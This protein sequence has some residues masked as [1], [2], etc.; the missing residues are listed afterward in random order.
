MCVGGLGVAAFNQHLQ[1]ETREW[2]LSFMLYFSS[3]EWVGD[4]N[5]CPTAREPRTLITQGRET[6]DA[7]TAPCST[8]PFHTGNVPCL[9]TLLNIIFSLCCLPASLIYAVFH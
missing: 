4:R 1:L 7:N 3:S 8:T 9:L 6:G 2:R 5:V